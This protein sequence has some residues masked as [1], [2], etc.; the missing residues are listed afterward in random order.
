[1]TLTAVRHQGV[2]EMFWFLFWGALNSVHHPCLCIY[3]YYFDYNLHV[4]ACP[5]TRT[6]IAG[7]REQLSAQLSLQQQAQ[8]KESMLMVPS[9]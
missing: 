3:Y 5:H 7:L 8:E 4:H 9:T 2:I 6:H 1:M